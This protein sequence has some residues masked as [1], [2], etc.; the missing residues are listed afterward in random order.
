MVRVDFP[1]YRLLREVA[2]GYSASSVDLERFFG[3]RFACES[4]GS[5][6]PDADELLIADLEGGV[7]FRLARKVRFGQESIDMSPVEAA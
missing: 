4:L 5:S 7:F 1:L 2:E 3:L 6:R